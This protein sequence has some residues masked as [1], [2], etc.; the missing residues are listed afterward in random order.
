MISPT[1]DSSQNVPRQFQTLSRGTAYCWARGNQ[2]TGHQHHK[3]RG[4]VPGRNHVWAR[5]HPASPVNGICTDLHPFRWR[6]LET[7]TWLSRACRTGTT[8]TPSRSRPCHSGTR[9]NSL[10]LSFTTFPLIPFLKNGNIIF[11]FF[12]TIIHCK[13]RLKK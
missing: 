3:E 5:S 9:T 10:T 4:Y 2:H 12:V 1:Q 8:T 13:P 7:R 11:N 6:R